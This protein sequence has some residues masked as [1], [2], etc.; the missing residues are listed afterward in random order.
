MQLK[1]GQEPRAESIARKLLITSPSANSDTDSVVA[2]PNQA[3]DGV[4]RLARALKK[5]LPLDKHLFIRIYT[6]SIVA[7]EE[8][9]R[10][11]VAKVEWEHFLV[12]FEGIESRETKRKVAEFRFEEYDCYLLHLVCMSDGPSDVVKVLLDASTY[13]V[14]SKCGMEISATP[15][16]ISPCPRGNAARHMC[17]LFQLEC[18]NCWRG[19]D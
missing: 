17:D 5:I 1:A 14:T 12:A 7:G 2:A 18:C 13:P 11:S 3:T 10:A 9:K 6:Q 19:P 8:E 15:L 4:E 16:H